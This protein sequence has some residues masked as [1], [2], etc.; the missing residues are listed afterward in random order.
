MEEK[1]LLDWGARIGAIAKAEEVEKHQLET[2][3]ASLE[4]TRDNRECLLLTAAFAHRQ[5]N[6]MEKRAGEER[7]LLGS[8]TAEQVCNALRELY[9]KGGTREDA[10]KVLGIAKW[11]H[12]AAKRL[13]QGRLREVKSL[14][15]FVDLLSRGEGRG[16]PER[17]EKAGGGSARL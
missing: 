7:P 16:V 8:R 9:Q 2:L 4:S 1:D 5:S 13:P 3:M 12:E 15:E 17:G 11:V 14:K 6:R 10:R